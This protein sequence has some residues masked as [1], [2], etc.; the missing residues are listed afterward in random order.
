MRAV[1]IFSLSL[2]LASAGSVRS[3]EAQ[4]LHRRVVFG[5]GV[6]DDANGARITA[7][8]PA[9][10]A[11]L[12][13]LSV[14]D[15]ITQ[16]R[17]EPVSNAAHFVTAVHMM[18]PDH[19]VAVTFLRSGTLQH[20][21]VRP[22]LAPKENDPVVETRYSSILVD[23]S[24]RRTL[25]SR[26]RAARG[27]MPAML[28]IGGIG[29]Y[30]IDNPADAHDAYRF[31]AHD[32]S[33][34]GIVV[35]RVEKAGMG[36]SEGGPCFDTDF[37]SELR[38]YGVALEALRSSQNVNARQVFLFGHSI[39]T[40]IAPRLAVNKAIA[41]IIVAEA[42][43]MNWFEYELSNLRRQSV[44]SGDSPGETDAVLRSKEKCMHRLLIER[45]SEAAIEADEPQCKLRNLYPVA[46]P[47][48]RQVA[49]LNVG[50]AWTKVDAPVLAIYGTSDFVTDVSE[51]RRIVDIVNAVH[52][53]TAKLITIEG[54]DHHFE[55]LG[56]PQQAY[57][58]RIRQHLQGPY[59][60]KLS[61][62]VRNGVCS[63]A[64]CP[65]K[66]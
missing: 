32:L 15:I 59:A 47:Y 5:A 57:F 26:P 6:V 3:V 33:R 55:L 29:C 35:M 65:S 38:S 40:L 64:D 31:L 8:I 42:V 58:A 50:E 36:D 20:V 62:V 25:I 34:A 39:G 10:P 19:S 28:L 13:R 12:A 52:P 51:H 4:E 66:R 46:A 44:L 9:S 21:D 43:G 60:Q 23:G 1:L 14:G 17:S 7:I 61:E 24:L 16:I 53:G 41:G 56:T 11:A 2:I 54:M 18:Q 27:D 30:T 22:V 49:E 37:N 48:M 63:Q 45:Q